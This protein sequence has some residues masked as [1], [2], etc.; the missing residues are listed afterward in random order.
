MDL[1]KKQTTDALAPIGSLLDAIWNFLCVIGK[2]IISK[3]KP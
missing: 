2:L 3:K 1:S